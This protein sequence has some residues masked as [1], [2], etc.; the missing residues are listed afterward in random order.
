MP[1]N[2]G[3]VAVL[4]VALATGVA[5]FATSARSAEQVRPSPQTSVTG[6]GA[7]SGIVVDEATGRPLAGAIVAFAS[8]SRGRNTV[9]IRP[10]ATDAQG[11]FIF[12]DLPASD[13]TVL[14]SR[15]GYVDGSSGLL[16]GTRDLTRVTLAPGQWI[17]DLRIA[18]SRLTAING[19]VVD[20][21]GEPVVGAYVRALREVFVG[22][23]I[24][25]A[26]GLATRTD[27]HGIYRIAGLAPGNY[28]VMV[29]SVQWTV[30]V[31]ATDQELFPTVIP[32]INGRIANPPQPRADPA[33]PIG[34]RSR[35][36]MNAYLPPAAAAG[37][38]L[39]AYPITFYP[40][41]RTLAEAT[42]VEVKQGDERIGIDI[43]IAPVRTWRVS[44]TV[45]GPSGAMLKGLPLRLMAAGLEDLGN[46]G[47]TATT[48]VS[49]DGTFTFANVPA[50]DYTALFSTSRMEYS[51]GDRASSIEYPMPSAPGAP[52]GNNGGGTISGALPG[53]EYGYSNPQGAVRYAGR[54]QMVVSGADVTDLLVAL[55]PSSSISGRI[56]HE[57]KAARP[58][59]PYD[60][61]QAVPANGDAFLGMPT[62]FAT[63]T[64]SDLT[65]RIPGLQAGPYVLR[66]SGGL[67]KSITCEGQDYTYKPFDGS[68]GRDY[69]DVL[70]TLTDAGASL[71]GSV[72]D[73]QNRVAARG[74]VII[75]PVEREQWS[76]YGLTARRISSQS[77][78]NG[79]YVTK[80]LPAGA[81]FAIAVDESLRNAWVDPKFLEIAVHQA[82]RTTLNWGET[83]TLDLVLKS[84]K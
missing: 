50:G 41:A 23:H 64:G 25:L 57:T 51:F 83:K 74:A 12:T 59:P 13:Y 10:Q 7:I 11:R 43:Q 1:R 42:T 34:D 27:D 61:V 5:A 60:S 78:G 6:T 55:K 66:M 16:S 76:G 18:L 72:R 45:Q 30:P 71:E 49:A 56:V 80:S 67:V 37:G 79:R 58:G 31:E 84:V 17:S 44:G 69:S 40:A 75:F 14:A 81:Y 82:S 68:A 9:P 77:L 54:A 3:R 8:M 36:I 52:S 48:V 33:I 4:A 22:G 73:S 70:I 19:T 53:L 65:F 2:S 63:V 39:S 20:E 38:A 35:W 21:T 28:I 15:I 26:S 62:E 32:L 24:H 47:E 29:P 46:G